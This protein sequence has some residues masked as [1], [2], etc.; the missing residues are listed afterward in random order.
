VG[1]AILSE[2]V[3]QPRLGWLARGRDGAVAATLED[4]FPRGED[5]SALGL[6][7]AMA[8][9]A[10]G[11][12]DLEGMGSRCRRLDRQGREEKE[13]EQQGLPPDVGS[14]AGR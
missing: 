12:E 7:L 6:V 4:R 3:D 9:K 10:L 13:Q 1:I 8:G 11:R 14:Y 5:E 2:K